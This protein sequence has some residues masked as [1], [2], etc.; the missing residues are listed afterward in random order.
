MEQSTIYLNFRKN[1]IEHPNN[2]A[3][4]YI[5]NGHYKKITYKKLNDLI[6]KIVSSFV[7]KNFVLGDRIAIIS[8]N[9]WEWPVVDLACNYLG[10]VLVPIHTTY[11]H[12]YI[13]YIISKTKPKN[14]FVSNQLTF[15]NLR[16][17][18]KQD[19]ES[20]E[21]IICFDDLDDSSITKF[22]DLLKYEQ[23]SNL[24]DPIKDISAVMTIIYTSGTTG[25]PKGA[26][27]TNR[28]I[29]SNIEN[30]LK[31]VPI[32]KSDR[33]FSVLPL[34]HI[35]ERSDGQMVPFLVGASIYY[36]RSSKTLVDDIVLAKPSIFIC[37][38]RIFERV[39]DKIQDNLRKSPK[40]K[41][42]LF[43]Y[44]L[45]LESKSNSLKRQGK[46]NIFLSGICTIFDKLVFGKI[47]NIFG[48][49]LRIAISGGSSLDKRIARFFEDIGIK[50]IEGYGLTET[51][52][53]ISVNKINNYKF[54][55]VGSC[56]PNL[57]LKIDKDKEILVRGDSVMSSYWDDEES[58]RN[59]IDKDNWFHTGD[60]GFVD[61]E[62]F[63]NIIGRKK[64]IILLSTGKNIV[65]INIEQALNYDKYINQSMIIGHNEKFLTA[66][67]VPDFEEIENY[68][69]LNNI[70]VDKEKSYLRLDKIQNFY[71]S[72]IDNC[73]KEFSSYEQV[74]HFYL[75]ERVFDEDHDELTP[76]LKLKREKI[77]E[78]FNNIIKE[79]YNN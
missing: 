32:Y 19:L 67:I 40:Y 54:G 25:M 60:L 23:A 75:V 37:V 64:E 69:V 36:S 12:K 18:N 55:T 53:I 5:Q 34:S 71:R 56:L 45:K 21:D 35:L 8:E 65:P 50:I 2:I 77:I 57:D 16:T 79:F 38:P 68:C 39:F 51:S 74:V 73:L 30:V 28:N 78:H 4:A 24:P 66:L 7:S 10:L 20:I 49:K 76:T 58:T 31:Y 27:L 43:Y 29:I 22:Q 41:S 9:R 62:G 72:R 26:I 70:L 14:V 46:K 63:L 42:Q 11:G 6:L 61:K 15:S 47:K 17:I 59:A 33:F 44:A 1:V 52:P 48:G 3:L 13:E